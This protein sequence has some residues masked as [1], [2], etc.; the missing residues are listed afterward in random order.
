[1]IYPRLYPGHIPAR[2]GGAPSDSPI[3][4]RRIGFRGARTEGPG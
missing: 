4:H 2:F 1:M 3:P